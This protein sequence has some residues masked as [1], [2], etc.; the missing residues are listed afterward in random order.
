M[1]CLGFHTRYLT[2]RH[3]SLS[4]EI[5]LSHLFFVSCFGPMM[6]RRQLFSPPL[7][8]QWLSA[9]HAGFRFGNRAKLQFQERVGHAE[10]NRVNRGRCILKSVSLAGVVFARRRRQVRHGT[11]A[12]NDSGR[13]P[14]AGGDCHV[15]TTRGFIPW[16]PRERLRSQRRA[17]RDQLPSVARAPQGQC[18]PDSTPIARSSFAP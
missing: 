5:G 2:S 16:G 11:S 7:P 3:A 6:R 18:R 8:A 10:P 14:R 13:D 15:A 4:H 1:I 17:P 9:N 12:T